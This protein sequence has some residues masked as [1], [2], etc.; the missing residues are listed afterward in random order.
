[1]KNKI[2]SAIYAVS[3]LVMAV[4]ALASAQLGRGMQ[5]AG[6]SGAP[7]GTIT[8][9]VTQIMYWLMGLVGVVGVIGFAIAGIL[10]LTAAGDEDRIGTAKKAMLYSIIGVIVAILGLVILKAAAS[11]LSGQSN[12]F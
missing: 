11:M 7:S 4:P 12:N 6:N 1:M 10:Y 3:A 5:S 2:K 9:I 8:D